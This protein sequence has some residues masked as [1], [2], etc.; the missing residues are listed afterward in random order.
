[1]TAIRSRADAA[2]A[3]GHD[4]I[5]PV[6]AAFAR[7][8]LEESVKCG[9]GRL[10][11]VSRD[12]WLLREATKIIAAE[13]HEWGRI[14][15]DYVYLSRR[16]TSLCSVEELSADTLG[17]VLAIVASGP[18][19][20]RIGD[21]F[22]FPLVELR[23]IGARIGIAAEAPSLDPGQLERLA[24]SNDFRRMT[25]RL[26]VDRSALVLCYLD[27]MQLLT[28]RT[29]LVDS[30]WRG[31][32]QAAVNRL[33]VANGHAPLDGYYI[34]LWNPPAADD[35]GRRLGLLSDS[36]RAG[37]LR[38]QAAW[39]NAYLIEI[40]CQSMEA[41]VVGYQE[42]NTGV[43]PVLEDA[44]VLRQTEMRNVELQ[45]CLQAGALARV[46]EAAPALANEIDLERLRQQTQSRL[47]RLAFFP[48]VD[49]RAV[50]A[51]LLHTEG[52]AV[53]WGANLLPDPTVHPF[54]APRRWLR[55]LAGAPWF[56]AYFMASG[57]H[58][59]AAAFYTFEAVNRWLPAGW[60]QRLKAAAVGTSSGPATARDDTP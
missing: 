27:Q 32:I 45:V 53:T 24:A 29:A 19:L 54:R 44:P 10:A 2:H 1:M 56:S 60:R 42:C 14:G 8:L 30:G 9:V 5:G 12:G 22:G 52:H 41:G 3:V 25:A 6:I 43:A 26:S 16:S 37:S 21:Y 50:G 46:R 20:A 4:L 48:G 39:Y 47:L 38:E 18:A 7:L 58:L 11:F 55:G 40:A 57:G 15:L 36:R 13:R 33:L 59:L 35:S 34:G 49:A 17:A 28:T 31:S 51:H 23:A